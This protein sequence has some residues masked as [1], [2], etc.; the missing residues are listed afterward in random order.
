M[1]IFIFTTPVE[2]RVSIR[3]ISPSHARTH[4]CSSTLRA[5]LPVR[6]FVPCD[7]FGGFARESIIH[8]AKASLLVSSGSI[9]ARGRVSRKTY[10]SDRAVNAPVRFTT[11]S[12]P[13]RSSPPPRPSCIPLRTKFP[14]RWR[15]L[16]IRMRS[17]VCLGNVGRANIEV[18][19][20][21]TSDRALAIRSSVAF[22]TTIIPPRGRSINSRL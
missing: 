8:E 4:R 2:L 17:S 11:A 12:S 6:Y 5:H 7:F 18:T 22:T 1:S 3:T 20:C 21:H 14:I 15:I 16:F 19:T 10:E 13:A 9:C